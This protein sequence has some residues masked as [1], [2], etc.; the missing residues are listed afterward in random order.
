MELME[1]VGVVIVF[2]LMNVHAQSS[3]IEVWVEDPLVKV[4]QDAKPNG[5]QQ[6]HAD[7]ARGE[8]ASL[9]I[10]VRS[11]KAIK[12]LRCEIGSL[13]IQGNEQVLLK[14]A[15]V[16]FV[17]YVPVNEPMQY[18]PKDQLRRPPAYFPDPLLEQETIDV[19]ANSSQPVWI[20]VSIPVTT[21]PGEYSG[22][23]QIS[24]IVDGREE[25]VS[26]GVSIRVFNVEVGPSRLWV[27]NWF[28]P[29]GVDTGI[30]YTGFSLPLDIAQLRAYAR[31]MAEHRQNVVR[32]PI[33]FLTKFGV[34]A[35]G[36]LKFDFSEFDK[37]VSLFIEEGVI[38]RIEGAHIAKRSGGWKSKF[39]VHVRKINNGA[40]ESAIADPTSQDADKFYGQFLPALVSHLK[41]KGWLNIYMQHQTDEPVP[42]NARSYKAIGAL[43]H[44][45]APELPRI[46]CLHTKE[47]VGAV[48]VWVPQ[49][50]YVHRDYDFYRERQRAGE[51]VWFYTAFWPQGEYAGRFIELPLLKTRILH[52]INYRYGITG[53]SHWGYNCWKFNGTTDPFTQTTPPHGVSHLPA[54]DAWIVYPG[55]GKPFDSMR[56]EAMRDGIADHELLSMLD[57]R[58]YSTEAQSL[59]ARHVID[60]SKYDCDIKK[61]RETRLELLNLLQETATVNFSTQA[62]IDFELSKQ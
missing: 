40:V 23:V 15:T 35:Q 9:Q 37:V 19:A 36:E 60:F 5:E 61:F 38:G 53:Y 12:A 3:T 34:G 29:T 52:W 11:L 58:D 44:K 49:L 7:V 31:N 54:G 17:G 59:A 25:S 41:E 56:H 14:G 50:N 42:E 8:H 62:A 57:E 6:A 18:P 2:T 48:D 46:D 10:V 26:A 13:Q 21:Q 24:G 30:S 43:L 55:P 20:T 51:E 28:Y 16:R 22:L 39:V 27:A 33:L 1:V 45:Y 32:I 47:V 4:F